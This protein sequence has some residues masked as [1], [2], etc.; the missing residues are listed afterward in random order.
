M[1]FS[2]I[3]YCLPTALACLTGCVGGDYSSGNGD[4][5]GQVALFGQGGPSSSQEV[6][7]K[8]NLEFLS[9]R[10]NRE[11]VEALLG[12]PQKRGSEDGILVE[13]E[14][15]RAVFDEVTGITF[16]WSR[17]ILTFEAGLCSEVTVDLQHPPPPETAGTVA[18]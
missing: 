9:L 7:R 4:Q 11:E 14:Y 3:C 18:D 16:G 12:S 2:S 6:V 8:G 10:R 5:A 17:V 15:R 1:K 13:W